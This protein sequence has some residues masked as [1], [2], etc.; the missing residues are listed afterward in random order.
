MQPPLRSSAWLSMAPSFCS[1]S[2]YHLLATLSSGMY[3]SGTVARC[4]TMRAH[5]VLPVPGGPSNSTACTQRSPCVHARVWQPC[6]R[7]T[8]RVLRRTFGRSHVP[9]LRVR[10]AMAA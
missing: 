9:D 5:V 10:L 3:T 7:G 6:W 1:L 4:A 2:P 8:A